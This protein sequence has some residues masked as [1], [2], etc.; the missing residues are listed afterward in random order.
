MSDRQAVTVGPQ[1]EGRSTVSHIHPLGFGAVDDDTIH[2]WPDD[3]RK[4]SLPQ[5]QSWL[6]PTPTARKPN[7][8][9]PK[10]REASDFRWPSISSETQR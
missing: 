2:E 9:K 5:G 1:P 7:T 4:S 3:G 6:K 8:I 10:H